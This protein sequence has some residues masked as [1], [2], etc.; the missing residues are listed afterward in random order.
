MSCT[1]VVSKITGV[2]SL[3]LDHSGS[4]MVTYSSYYWRNIMP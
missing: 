2:A 1:G 3:D 4:H